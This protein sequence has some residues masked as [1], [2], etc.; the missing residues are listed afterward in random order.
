MHIYLSKSKNMIHALCRITIFAFWMVF[1]SFLIMDYIPRYDILA[2]LVLIVSVVEVANMLMEESVYNSGLLMIFFLYTLVVHNGFVVSYIFD[3]SYATFQSVGSMA[4]LGMETFPKAIVIANTVILTFVLS[5]MFSKSPFYYK[6]EAIEDR[7][8]V[9][10]GKKAADIVGIAFLSFGTLFLAY[11]V[12]TNRL[13]FIGYL[14]V[15]KITRNIPLYLHVI[16]F[17]SLA[18]AFLMAAG[19]KKGVRIG[20]VIYLITVLLH[21]A[22]GNRGEVL[23]SAVVC[24]ALY[25][26]RFRKIK[27]RHIVIAAAAMIVLIPLVRIAREL[28]LNSYTLNPISAFLD[29]LCEEGLEISPFTHIVNYVEKGNPHVWGMTYVND[30]WDFIARRIGVN[31]TLAQTPYV[32]T[33]IMPHSGMGFSMIAELYYNFTVVGACVVYILYAQLIKNLDK[34]S[35]CGEL[36]DNKRLLYSMMMVEMINLTRNDASTLPVYLTYSLI[37]VIIYKVVG[38]VAFS[39]SNRRGVV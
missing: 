36:S 14:N 26:I 29:V 38:S 23:Y 28:A 10:E 33:Q 27:T 25:S 8:N 2:I 19:T 21:F 11:I 18:I 15:L 24:F 6:K 22:I 39:K 1:C 20:V 12:F 9:F 37:L 17:T 7:S 30:F 35:F 16:V 4:F 5:A 3:K 32:I 31:N 34:K 13:W